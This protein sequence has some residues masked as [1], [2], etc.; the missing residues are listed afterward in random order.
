[1]NHFFLFGF[2]K[3][4]TTFLQQLVD[5]HPQ[6]NCPPEHHFN[7]VINAI[8]S[9]CPQ[10]KS[11]IES[12]DQRT[13][14][15]G[16]RFDDSLVMLH[17]FRGFVEAFMLCGA[18]SEATHAGVNDNSMGLNLEFVAKAFPKSKFVAILRDP[19]EIAVSLFHHKQRTEPEFRKKMELSLMWLMR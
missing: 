9:F 7:S 3:S 10:Y 8:R 5:S 16:I 1:M 15:Q 4:G 11:I 18:D 12:F 6:I 17:A 14:Q 19:R 13:G 2:N